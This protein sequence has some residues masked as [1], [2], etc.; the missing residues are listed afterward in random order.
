MRALLVPADEGGCGYNRIIW[1]GEILKFR[2][3]LDITFDLQAKGMKL[4]RDANGDVTW[5]QELDY[6]VIVFQ[7]AMTRVSAQI[8][9][10]IR[11]QG[12]AVVCELDDDFWSPD[13]RSPTFKKNSASNN[14]EAN[15][16]HLSASCREA[17][18]VT[19]STPE[20]ARIVPSE[21]TRVIKNCVPQRYFDIETTPFVDGD[22]T[23]DKTVVGWTG[24][25]EFHAGDLTVVGD[26][27][28]RAVRTCNGIFINLGDER[29]GPRMGFDDAEALYH[30]W[31]PLSDYPG[32][33]KN[34]A[35][36]LV[37]LRDF[38]FN[39]AKSWLKGLEYASL[40]IPFV[41]SP[42]T[43]YRALSKLGAGDLAAQ[44]HDWYKVLAKLLSDAPYREQR[45]HDGLETAKTLTYEEHAWKWAE[46]WELAIDNRKKAKY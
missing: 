5:V 41:A 11:T 1:P 38:R 28:R 17:D 24:D 13:V 2:D 44:K 12:I 32:Y 43:E 30:P 25:L 18:L 21:K 34:F 22:L 27:V 23:E 16:D 9:R 33:I 7:R 14:P 6:D 26:G 8:I 37:P 36:G 20:L 4:K 29:G 10:L 46:A 31:V 42:V 40:G 3:G 15:P 45:A 19:V 39:H 35:L